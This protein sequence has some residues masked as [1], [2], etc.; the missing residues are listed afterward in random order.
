MRKIKKVEIT[1][2]KLNAAGE[3]AVTNNTSIPAFVIE[4]VQTTDG[5]SMYAIPVNEREIE[6]L[7]DAFYAPYRTPTETK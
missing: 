4:R 6:R 7:E 2:E 1:P 5:V 3:Y